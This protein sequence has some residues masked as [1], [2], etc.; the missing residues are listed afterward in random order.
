MTTKNTILIDNFEASPLIASNAGNLG[1]RLR[2]INGTVALATTDLDAGDI[3]MIAPVPSNARILSIKLAADDLDGATTPLL[4]WDVG[5]H[6]TAGVAKDIDAYASLITL[7]Q[8]ATVFTEFA[9]EARGIEKAGQAVYQDA[10][11][12]SDPGGLFYLSATVNA[13]AAT[14]VAGDF[15][16]IV[17]YVVS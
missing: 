9:F 13:G 2:T 6:T 14:A 1:G 17:E 7:G 12:V 3:L 8:A 11:D 10:G 15:S 16:F 4:T 5:L